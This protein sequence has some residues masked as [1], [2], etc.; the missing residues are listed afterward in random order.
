MRAHVLFHLSKKKGESNKMRG[1]PNSIS[2][3]RNEFN[4]FDETR[5]RMFDSIY[6]MTLEILK[7]PIFDLKTSRFCHLLCNFIMDVTKLRK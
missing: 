4:K 1:L 6:H 5:A 7:N 2:L 3:F